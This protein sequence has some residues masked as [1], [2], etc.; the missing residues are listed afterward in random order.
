MRSFCDRRARNSRFC[1]SIVARFK[2]NQHSFFLY[3]PVLN[4]TSLESTRTTWPTQ[5]KRTSSTECTRTWTTWRSRCPAIRF[6]SWAP[7]RNW[8]KNKGTWASKWI[9]EYRIIRFK[10]ELFLL[11]TTRNTPCIH[12]SSRKCIWKSQ[13]HWWFWSDFNEIRLVIPSDDHK[14]LSIFPN[15]HYR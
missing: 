13:R 7:T 14:L 11:I 10:P 2:I 12:R 1:Q 15:V 6:G 9:C 3:H 8:W 5:T 4:S